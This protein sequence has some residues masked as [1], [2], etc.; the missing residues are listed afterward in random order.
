M[1]E[2]PGP[3]MSTPF[4]ALPEMMLP[5]PAEVPPIVAPVTPPPISKPLRF[6]SAV[7]PEISVPTKF[8]STV[9]SDVPLPERKTPSLV[10]PEMTLRAPAMLPP[11]RF[12]VAPVSISTPVPLARGVCPE[13]AVPMKSPSTTLPVVPAPVISTPL[14]EL[15]EMMLRAPVLVPPIEVGRRARVDRHA[16]VVG[17]GRLARDPRADR[18]AL[19]HV[20]GRPGAGYPH[21]NAQVAREHIARGGNDAADQVGS[22]AEVDIHTG[23]VAQRRLPRNSGADEVSLDDVARRSRPR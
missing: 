1:P 16:D 10:L 12:A 11:T 23:V 6:P 8:P 2:A 14:V 18:V 5:A 4:A 13:T 15:P 7:A 19:D 22:R 20:A 21:T 9:L 17:Q 3:E